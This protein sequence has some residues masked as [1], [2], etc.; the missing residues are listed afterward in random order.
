MQFLPMDNNTH[1]NTTSEM[2]SFCIDHDECDADTHKC[3]QHCHN[4]HGSYYC[5]CD[6]GYTLETDGKTCKGMSVITLYY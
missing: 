5:T 3:D 6:F 2:C 4:S 1:Y